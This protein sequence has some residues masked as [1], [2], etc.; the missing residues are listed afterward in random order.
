MADS[1]CI[2]V[3]EQVVVPDAVAVKETVALPGEKGD[4]GDPFTYDDFTP[5]QI[6]DLQRPA[7]EAAAVANQA[8]ENANKATSDIKALGVTLTAEEAKRESAESSR[9]SAESERAEAEFQRETSFSQMQTTL[10]ELITDTR[11]ATSNANTAAG[12]AE[13]AAT[14]ANNSATLANA[15]ADKA[16]QAAQNVDGRVTSLEEKAS[17]VYE[18][19]AAIEASGETNPNKIYID[20]ETMQPYIYK[21]GE[22]VKFSGAE[23]KV[24]RDVLDFPIFYFKDGLF[25]YVDNKGKLCSWNEET[26]EVINYNIGIAAHSYQISAN[27]PFIYRDGKIIVPTSKGATCYNLETKEELWSITMTYYNV[28]FNEYKDFIYLQDYSNKSIIK[29]ISIEDGSTIQ[30]FNLTELSGER[31]GDVQDFGECEINGYCY[32]SNSSGH[33]FKISNENGYIEYVGKI[34]GVENISLNNG[35]VFM[36][37]YYNIFSAEKTVFED[38]TLTTKNNKKHIQDTYLEFAIKCKI[39]NGTFYTFKYK[40]SI[41]STFFGIYIYENLDMSYEGRGKAIKGNKGYVII[42]VNNTI[43]GKPFYVKYDWI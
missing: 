9:A 35:Y 40:I 17:Q 28:I 26:G 21:D 18:N 30:E 10:E 23:T 42:K 5:E 34:D 41:S 6:A 12:N 19:L 15:A 14:E 37:G 43:N 11:T 24:F 1:D 25:F 38:G 36:L 7:T 3:H 32:F 39:I 20:G 31:S 13:N 8:A 22:F 27:F 33:I 4:K 16:N 29:L 2:I